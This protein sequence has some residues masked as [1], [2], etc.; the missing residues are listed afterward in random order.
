MKTEFE[1]KFFPI[2]KDAIR[3]VLKSVDAQLVS[4]ERKMRRIIFD[5]RENA[6]VKADY[7][8][9][10]DEG[11]AVRLSAK[12]HAGENGKLED[13]KETDVEVQSFD[14]TVEI[15]HQAGLIES[16]YQETLRETWDCQGA[17]VVI[18]TWP[19]LPCYIEVEASSE[20]E[21]KKVSELLGMNWEERRITS[22]VEV[23]A[24]YFKVSVEEVLNKLKKVTFEDLPF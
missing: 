6:Q 16:A 15:L 18:D 1:A 17:E 3:E 10:R 24:E 2:D 12:T 23:Y 22:V 13:Q 7:I 14:D 8:R 20:E 4:P 21:V 5:H 9:V 11:N 19:S